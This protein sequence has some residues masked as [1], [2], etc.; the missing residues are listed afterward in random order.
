MLSVGS[1]DQPTN[2]SSLW[3]PDC[4]KPIP[5][6]QWSHGFWE[7]TKPVSNIDCTRSTHEFVSDVLPS[8]WANCMQF[9]WWSM[10]SCQNR[11]S[12]NLMWMKP[13]NMMAPSMSGITPKISN[14][15]QSSSTQRSSWSVSCMPQ[16]N[17]K[18][19]WGQPLSELSMIQSFLSPAA[20][21]IFKCHNPN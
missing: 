6:G 7:G 3:Y 20:A 17:W 18:K 12:W 15:T 21:T 10:N 19:L 13:R 4:Q 8:P 11:R 5:E 9:P 16:K 14:T 2:S 1:Y